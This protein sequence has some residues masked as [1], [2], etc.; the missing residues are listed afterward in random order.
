MQVT[1]KALDTF[2]DSRV[3]AGGMGGSVHKGQTA[4]T[5]EDAANELAKA[6]L[7]EIVS[8]KAEEKMTA[9]EEKKPVTE[10]KKQPPVQNK[11]LTNK[12]RSNKGK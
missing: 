8:Q 11:M 7:V 9:T 10:E 4:T 12:A 3:H 1:I 6:G 5:S 2:H